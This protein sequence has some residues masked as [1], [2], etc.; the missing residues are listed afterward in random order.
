MITLI[1][2][3]DT[4]PATY[5]ENGSHFLL[6]DVIANYL[7][8]DGK[9]L[10]P[11][12][13]QL[14]SRE[15]LLR[16]GN[17][18]EELSGL[19]DGNGSNIYLGSKD[20]V[21]VVDDIERIIWEMGCELRAAGRDFDELTPTK[22]RYNGSRTTS[23]AATRGGRESTTHTEHVT[24]IPLSTIVREILED[25]EID[26]YPPYITRLTKSFY[27][28][29]PGYLSLQSRGIG[30]MVVLKKS[31]RNAIEKLLEPIIAD[32]MR[33][34]QEHKSY[35][36]N[37]LEIRKSLSY[38]KDWSGKKLSS[39][40]LKATWQAYRSD[41]N[42]VDR[43]KLVG[44]YLTHVINV[45]D[46]HFNVYGGTIERDDLISWGTDGLLQAIE[47]FDP[48]KGYAFTS[49]SFPRIRGAIL[50]NIK[51]LDDVSRNDRVRYKVISQAS[52]KLEQELGR[53]PTTSE[54]AEKL[55]IEPDEIDRIKLAGTRTE[56]SY[57]SKDGDGRLLLRNVL[58]AGLK[59]DS[60]QAAGLN[61]EMERVKKNLP[62]K[63]WEILRL[64]F[65]EDLTQKEIGV[66]LN[67]SESRI[68]Q[69]QNK[70]LAHLKEVIPYN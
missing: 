32:I 7:A 6:E 61:D 27:R 19:A 12:F 50:D 33:A 29:S 45:A 68:C 65:F 8:R 56:I 28:R 23:S 52:D 3:S 44:H 16:V 2:D 42:M 4:K 62:P 34:T 21:I 64:Y 43:D 39:D 51:A 69:L 53:V 40:E 37:K 30:E 24:T 9:R 60:L 57:D 35:D 66:R 59:Y 18:F 54:L 17:P 13:L 67:L 41:A 49:Y 25:K 47:R 20:E 58:E 46:Y 26:V 15:L 36:Y 63:E 10:D 48:D 11:V 70:A 14:M 5:G 31:D 38:T 22:R 1:A 55:R